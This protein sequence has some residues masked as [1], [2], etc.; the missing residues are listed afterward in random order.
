MF[1]SFAPACRLLIG[2][3]FPPTACTV[4]TCAAPSQIPRA[5]GAIPVVTVI[6]P[7]AAALKELLKDAESRVKTYSAAALDMEMQKCATHS[8]RVS[9]EVP[10]VL[11]QLLTQHIGKYLSVLLLVKTLLRDRSPVTVRLLTDAT[12]CLHDLYSAVTHSSP[13]YKTCILAVQRLVYACLMIAGCLANPG[14]CIAPTAIS[15][16]HSVM[17]V[18]CTL[19]AATLSMGTLAAKASAEVE[20]LRAQLAHLES[21]A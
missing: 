4:P 16:W 7:D 9:L 6:A 18:W 5:F 19:Q 17:I 10:A 11:S 14:N 2:H 20:T 21:S 3:Q 15:Y 13:V 8:E 12:C 1:R